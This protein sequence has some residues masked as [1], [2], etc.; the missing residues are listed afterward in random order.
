M[1]HCFSLYLPKYYRIQGGARDA[2]PLSVS[3]LLLP[4]AT[5]LGQG[6]IFTSVCQEF[7]PQGGEGVCLSACWDTP[8]REQT[9]REQTPPRTRQTP[10]PREAGSSIRST[11]G[12]YASY[13]NAFLFSYSFEEKIWPNNRL[14]PPSWKSWIHHS[15]ACF[16]PLLVSPRNSIVS[17]CIRI[18]S[19]R[20]ILRIR[21]V[22]SPLV[23]YLSPLFF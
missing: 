23:V 17:D 1:R 10:L 16:L 15:S 11:S 5:K 9:P 7:C 3:S 12:R 21:H 2:C 14:T 4:A 19:V 22:P 13:W 20:I 18:V 8:P 6:N